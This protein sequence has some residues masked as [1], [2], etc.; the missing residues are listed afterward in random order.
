M[1]KPAK[2]SK[3]QA[4]PKSFHDTVLGCIPNGAC[5]PCSVVLGVEAGKRCSNP[6]MRKEAR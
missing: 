3:P 6:R 4:K 5:I 2:K 1:K